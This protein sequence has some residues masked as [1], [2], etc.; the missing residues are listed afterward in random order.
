MWEDVCRPQLRETS[1]P[2]GPSILL[3]VPGTNR[4]NWQGGGT[5]H[6]NQEQGLS[7]WC[8]LQKPPENYW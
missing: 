7:E 4:M 2:L 1:S 8:M 6:S 3:D 5:W